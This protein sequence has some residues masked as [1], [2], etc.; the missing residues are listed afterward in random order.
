MAGLYSKADLELRQSCPGKSTPR[1]ISAILMRWMAAHEHHRWIIFWA[2]RALR[3]MRLS[4][5]RTT[6]AC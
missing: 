1:P 5:P 2:G 3:L 4:W 6:D